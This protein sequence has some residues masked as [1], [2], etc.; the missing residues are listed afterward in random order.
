MSPVALLHK[1]SQI[2]S[3]TQHG[4]DWQCLAVSGLAHTSLSINTVNL[5]GMSERQVRCAAESCLRL[6]T[7]WV[8]SR[9]VFDREK[10]HCLGYLAWYGCNFSTHRSGS[11][12]SAR[13]T[14]EPACAQESSLQVWV[15]RGYGA[16]VNS[17][18]WSLA[19]MGGSAD[20]NGQGLSRSGG[21]NHCCHCG[22][23]VLIL[24]VILVSSGVVIG[25]VVS[26]VM[27]RPFDGS[28]RLVTGLLYFTLACTTFLWALVLGCS[29][30]RWTRVVTGGSW[31][32]CGVA[33]LVSCLVSFFLLLTGCFYSCTWASQ[34]WFKDGSWGWDGWSQRNSDWSGC[35]VVVLE[36][37]VIVTI[38]SIGGGIVMLCG[39]IGVVILWWL[40]L[41]IV[42]LLLLSHLWWRW[43]YPWWA[44]GV[45]GNLS[46][47][48]ISHM[49]VPTIV[50]IRE[51]DG[52][53]NH[54]G[55]TAEHTDV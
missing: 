51:A 43:G 19:Y 36:L 46:K 2:M 28:C 29:W 22:V 53:R 35:E 26:A 21:V 44:L 38:V 45:T 24:T 12:H 13:M 20:Q 9:W 6:T 7:S 41:V 3:R 50:C 37:V 16:G 4:R 54:M 18:C 42:R 27:D 55:L 15:H 30:F 11:S 1:I 14:Q 10:K 8:V 33:A 39:G 40:V 47:G 31:L 52:S 23:V 32:V 48:V 17:Q 34:L 25:V 49:Q 5:T